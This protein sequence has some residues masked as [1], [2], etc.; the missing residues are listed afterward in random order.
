MKKTIAAVGL[1]AALGVPAAVHAPSSTEPAKS[2]QQAEE[3]I[4]CPLTGEQIPPCCC[5]VNDDE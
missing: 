5:P 4:T 3:S 2:Q 1:A